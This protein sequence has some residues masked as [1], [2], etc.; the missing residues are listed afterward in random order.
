M[1][2]VFTNAVNLQ[3]DSPLFSKIPQELR[4]EIFDLVVT[5][6]PEKHVHYPEELRYP[7][8]GLPRLD[9]S[10]SATLLRCCQL[11]YFQ[12]CD[13]PAKK[14]VLVDW[15]CDGKVGHGYENYK[16]GNN[17]FDHL[18]PKA[19]RNLHLFTTKFWL[20]TFQVDLWDPYAGKI[21]AQAPNLEY[22]KTT[23]EHD[24]SPFRFHDDVVPSPKRFARSIWFWG[25]ALWTFEN[26]TLMELEVE[27]LEEQMEKLDLVLAKAAAWRFS[28]ASGRQL[29]LNSRKT[30]WEGWHGPNLGKSYPSMAPY[31]H[32]I[33][34]LSNEIS[35]MGQ[36]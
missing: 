9:R 36:I 30:K 33:S 7:R 32:V 28:L 17:R 27:T 31:I 2:P 14:Y 35:S 25:H 11:I 24:N 1:A 26:L 15:L 16:D 22:L 6:H 19:L 5:P 18:L 23:L 10:L 4:N 29:V 3:K 34:T 13:L 8:P 20:N 21:A 12:T